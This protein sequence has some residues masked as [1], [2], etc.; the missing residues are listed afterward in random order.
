MLAIGDPGN[1]AY[2]PMRIGE[3]IDGWELVEIRDK[4]VLVRS[5]SVEETIIM[6]GPTAQIPREGNRTLARAAPSPAVRTVAAPAQDTAGTARNAPAASS[7]N[8]VAN[9]NDEPPAGFRV[10]K[11][12][13]GNRL[14]PIP[15][16]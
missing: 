16:P 15:Q 9:R 8:P 7:R 4:A 2:R 10:M 6:N 12:P 11:T 14:I 5:G 3:V 13:W 1:R